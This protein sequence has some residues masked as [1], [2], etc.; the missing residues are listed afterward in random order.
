[1]RIIPVFRVLGAL[2][3]GL[4][5]MMVVPFLADYFSGEDP[6]Y[7]VIAILAAL[8]TGATLLVLGGTG[9]TFAL[10][11]RQAFLATGLTWMV[12]PAFAAIPFLGVGLDHVR[13]FFEATSGITTTGATVMTGLDRAPPGILLWRSI[14]HALGGVGIVV[15]GV[16]VLPFLRIAGMQL[17]RTESSDQSEKIFAKGLDLARWIIGIYLVLNAL[18]AA[19]FALLGMSAFDAINHAL[20]TISTGGFSTHDRS[21]GHF[22]SAAIEWAGVLFMVAGALPF[23]AYIR[24]VRQDRAALL[25]DPQARVFIAFL[26]AASVVLAVTRAAT[27]GLEFDDALRRA[28]FHVV[29][30]VTTSGFSASDYQAWGAYAVSAFFVLMFL[31]GCSGSTAGGV[32]LYR[33]QILWKLATAHLARLVSPSRIVVVTYSTRRVDDEAAF[34]ILT[35][36]VAYLVSVA[37]VALILGWFGLDFVTAISGAASAIGNV[38]PGL[39]PIIGPAGNF[40]TLPDAALVVLS[41]AM[42]FGRLEF[43]T[44]LVLLT[45]AFWRD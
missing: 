12:L 8:F 44:L 11:R 31:G 7:Y 30:I 21:Y 13:A 27:D 34:A 29:S 43:F 14:L 6:T 17:F 41:I 1:M 45:P 42:I 25:S 24:T 26:A 15:L 19:V 18:C 40:S 16:V 22:E 23:V 3:V 33:I 38:G 36:L 20:S 5:L 10:T 39:G 9:E 4:A 2:L 32:K 35:F 37:A 28:S